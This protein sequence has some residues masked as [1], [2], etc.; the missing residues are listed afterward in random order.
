MMQPIQ[1]LW[2][3][4]R[5]SALEQLSIR[6]F[7]AHGHPYHLYAYE[8]ISGV[9]AGVEIRNAEEILPSSLV[10]KVQD[11]YH[12]GFS[13]WFRWK[14]LLERGGWWADLDVVALRPF[15]FLGEYAFASE[16]QGQTAIPTSG[17]ILAPAGA[18][19]LGV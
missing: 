5:L 6:S 2:I 14:L 16:A 12:A 9:P 3:G 13:D 8:K 4:P 1:G 7:L 18:P 10:F 15:A 17:V 11:G 19:A